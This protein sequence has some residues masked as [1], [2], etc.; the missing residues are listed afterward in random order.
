MNGYERADAVAPASVRESFAY[1]A[2]LPNALSKGW[3]LWIGLLHI[4]IVVCYNLQANLFGR[5][6]DALSGGAVPGLGSGPRAFIAAIAGA[7]VLMLIEIAFRHVSYY[8]IGTKVRRASIDLRRACLDAI[9]RA[10][11]PRV[12]ELGTGNVITRMT[13][14]ID[15]VVSVVSRIGVRV[16]TT[17]FVFPLTALSLTLIDVRFLLI[18]LIVAA[19][20]YPF[21][22]EVIRSIPQ[23]TNAVSVAEARRNAVLLDTLRGRPTL[24]AFGLERWALERMRGASWGAVRAEMD[25]APWFIRMTGIGQWAF[26]AWLIATLLLGG[27]LANNGTLTPGQASAAAFLVVRAEVMVFNAI[28]FVGELQSAATS[29]GRAVSLAT[30]HAGR[31]AASMPADLMQPPAVE[32]DRVTFAYPGGANVIE[33]L[34]VTLEPGSTTAL[35][36]TSGAGKSTLAALIAGLVE[37][38]GGTIRIG[39]VDT[40]SVSDVWTSRN[41][42]LVSQ[43]VHVFAGSLR[44]DLAM[45]AP[46]ASDAELASALGLVGLDP[47]SVNFQRLFPEGM[48]T[49]VGAGA[50]DLPPEVE[51]QIAL[52]R[53]ALA[54]PQVLILDEATAEAGSDDTNTLEAAAAALAERA[55]SLVVAHRLDQA[56]EADR[57][58]VMSEGKIIEDGT[59]EQLLAAQGRYAQL[60]AAWSGGGH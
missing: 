29:L 14:D 46:G 1:L 57:I 34:S 7:M 49:L 42:T 11:V 16:L 20:T 54:K 8:A 60:F 35:V 13:K 12:M 47:G 51:Q 52:A 40:G 5:S 26:G 10:P 53:V 33:D 9:L 19:A 56:K 45:A 38:T 50:E 4:I 37:P 6:V 43:E 39:G 18:F 27:Y 32:I 31:S 44:E 41:V 55:T 22:R 30:L 17:V 36:G 15:D 24:R 25:R 3:W 21:A 2:A 58:L 48:D 28:F 59:H 23:V